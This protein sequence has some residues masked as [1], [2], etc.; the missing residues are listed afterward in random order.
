MVTVL[1]RARRVVVAFL[2]L[3]MVGGGL[4]FSADRPAEAWGVDS[5]T[6]LPE[7]T[8]NMPTA[9]VGPGNVAADMLRLPTAAD[10]TI[11]VQGSTVYELLQGHGQ[12]WTTYGRT[13]D[14]KAGC[15]ILDQTQT[16]LANIILAGNDLLA[17]TGILVYVAA[18][19]DHGMMST[20]FDKTGTAVHDLNTK[21]FTPLAKTMFIGIGIW[22]MVVGATKRNRFRELISK[23]GSA[24]GTV[25]IVSVCI[26]AGWYVPTVNA[27]DG[28]TAGGQEV[29][30]NMLLSGNDEKGQPCSAD[31][32][33]SQARRQMACEMWYSTSFTPWTVGMYGF[34]GT[35]PMPYAGPDYTEGRIPDDFRFQQLWTQTYSV[36]DQA[37][38]D[39]A[40]KAAEEGGTE[41]HLTQFADKQEQWGQLAERARKAA[42]G[43]V[44]VTA[45]ERATWS[46]AYGGWR[47]EGA[48]SRFTT[49]LNAVGGTIISSIAEVWLSILNL[50]YQVIP[51]MLLVALPVI[52]LIAMIPKMN[53]LMGECF[54]LLGKS[55]IMRVITAGALALLLMIMKIILEMDMAPPLTGLYQL[56]VAIGLLMIF[57]M[58]KKH[59]TSQT[60]LEGEGKGAVDS[61][62]NTTTSTVNKLAGAGD[63]GGGAGGMWTVAGLAVT[64]A[65]AR[66]RGG[67]ADA[68]NA[69]KNDAD[70]EADDELDEADEPGHDERD[71][72]LDGSGDAPAD[73]GGRHSA[74][75]DRM[76]MWGRISG[77]LR[78]AA[79]DLG[80]AADGLGDA[81]NS[82]ADAVSA[83]DAIPTL[84][85]DGDSQEIPVVAPAMARMGVPLVPGVEISEPADFIRVD[86]G[87]Q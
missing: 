32:G 25:L 36:N 87:H 13:V 35:E 29:L 12:W 63:G 82:V 49:A 2:F 84:E 7:A 20:L 17:N 23:V 41:V 34:V 78:G 18:T 85:A 58:A 73:S 44:D 6:F 22:L 65:V 11:D 66:R 43:S 72:E 80:D 26:T 39:A 14:D 75:T 33:D 51:P 46:A 62:T 67:S 74:S 55:F 42:D 77:H 47:G 45:T 27:L 38:M 15:N 9:I 61:T 19:G 30:T 69:G 81:A 71:D 4:A 86:G 79:D 68:E 5:C 37:A 28:Y 8:N 59:M 52:A 16:S 1:N 50:A 10:G 76:P 53:F 54:T 24:M 56:V 40:R 64:S 3:V 60:R 31:K 57:R 70:D 83:V 21:F 48:G